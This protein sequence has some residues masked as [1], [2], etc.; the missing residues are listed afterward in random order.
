MKTLALCLVASAALADINLKNHGTA[1]GP[2]NVLNCTGAATCSR[3][4][5][6]GNVSCTTVD[7]GT[8]AHCDAGYVIQGDGGC[9]TYCH[10]DLGQYADGGCI[11]GCYTPPITLCAALDAGDFIGSKAWCLKGDGTMSA[12]SN[13]SLYQFGSIPAAESWPV[14]PDGTLETMTRLNDISAGSANWNQYWTSDGGQEAPVAS[15]TTCALMANMIRDQSALTNYTNAF[16]RFGASGAIKWANVSGTFAN[17]D[18]TVCKFGAATD[19]AGANNLIGVARRAM[20]MHCAVFTSGDGGA[21]TGSTASYTCAQDAGCR[22]VTTT[23]IYPRIGT[24]GSK[25]SWYVGLSQSGTGSAEMSDVWFRG[26]FMTE[27]ALSTA[28]LQRLFG[29]V[30]PTVQ[31]GETFSRATDKTCCNASNQCINLPV[32]TPCNNTCQTEVDQRQV[33]NTDAAPEDTMTL[34]SFNVP[35]DGG[36]AIPVATTENHAGPFGFQTAIKYTFHQTEVISSD[37]GAPYAWTESKATSCSGLYAGGTLTCSWYILGVTG[38]EVLDACVNNTAPTLT[39]PY[40]QQCTTFTPS[41]ST[42]GR[43][44]VSGRDVLGT[45]GCIIGNL[46]QSA[47]TNSQPNNG[48]GLDAKIHPVR[49]LQSAWITMDQCDPISS[50]ATDYSF[51]GSST[52]RAPET[53]SGTGCP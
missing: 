16:V 33:L 4:G 53:C 49:P 3:D 19:C 46:T 24:A 6:W 18:N 52:L 14:S 2:V 42:W 50:G 27:K 13:I 51:L 32:N 35:L 9:D 21:A 45:A 36:S 43:Y 8:C 23:H 41:A 44:S 38:S 11:R 47:P 15:F 5:G 28:D 22:A 26:A 39:Q 17:G 40:G 34:G 12:A 25:S 20:A 37:A 31:S 29:L 48:T 30:L 10:P 1:L 7:A